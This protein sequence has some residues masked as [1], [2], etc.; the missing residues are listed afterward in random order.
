MTNV[1]RYDVWIW[2]KVKQKWKRTSFEYK[3]AAMVEVEGHDVWSIQKV[4]VIASKNV[5][6]FK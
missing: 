1:T 2:D 3:S 5:T 6:L 4:E